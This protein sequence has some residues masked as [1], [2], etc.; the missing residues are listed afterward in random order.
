MAVY[1]HHKN[2]IRYGNFVIHG[3]TGHFPQQAITSTNLNH[4][5][6][7]NKPQLDFGTN[8]LE[9]IEKFPAKLLADYTY[10][11]DRSKTISKIIQQNPDKLCLLLLNGARTIRITKDDNLTLIKFQNDC[12][13]QLVKVFFK[14]NRNALE[15][16]REYRRQTLRDKSLVIVIDENLNHST[17]KKLY[18]DA[19]NHGDEIIGFLGREPKKSNDEQKLNFQFLSSRENDRVIRLVSFIRKSSAGVVSSLIY[20]LFGLDVY[21]FITRFGNPNIPQMKIN[22]L[23]KFTYKPLTRSGNFT[24]VVTHTNLYNSSK[25]FEKENRSSIPI[26]IHDIVKLNKEFSKLQEKYTRIQLELIAGKRIF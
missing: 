20:H 25:R 15:N 5:K 4:A 7:V 2:G 26:S 9:I 3:I 17:F 6:Y 11:N 13:F 10:R 18:T 1:I 14:N 12:G 22:V 24:C 16:S 21:S 23:D 8:F 19:Y